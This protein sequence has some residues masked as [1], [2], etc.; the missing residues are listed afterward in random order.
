MAALDKNAAT[1]EEQEPPVDDLSIMCLTGPIKTAINGP[2]EARDAERLGFKG[3]WISERYTLKE[4]GAVLGAM[5][6][7]TKRITLG[8]SPIT[9]AARYPV[10]TAAMIATLQSMFGNRVI[11][12]VGRGPD[13]NWLPGHGFGSVDTKTFIDWVNILRQLWRGEVVNYDGPVGKF[14]GLVMG[15]RNETPPPLIFCH[16]GGPKASKLA[17]QPMFDGVFMP[18]IMSPNAQGRSIE[19]TLEECKRIGRDPST[20]RFYAAVSA[21]PD[22]DEQ[23]MRME[24]GN[25]IVI[26]LSQ[27]KLGEVFREL[28]GW[29]KETVHALLN[30]DM[31]KGSK[32]NLDLNF[33]REQ[34]V[35]ATMM[36]PQKWIEDVA[37]VGTAAECAKNLQRYK[38]AG[39]QEVVIWGGPPA[40][41]AGLIREWRARKAAAAR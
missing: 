39:V 21:V 4:V 16:M 14:E 20:L 25:R 7:V 12:G 22:A 36:I 37:A 9:I 10:V 33:T 2:Q 32:G 24:I 11:A 31:F 34:M 27:P 15:Q 40:A 1:T 3:V 35:K 28:N 26:N 29:D 30:Q 18:S 38:D 8:C 17:A 41:N 19:M 13:G 5:G 6:A 23:A